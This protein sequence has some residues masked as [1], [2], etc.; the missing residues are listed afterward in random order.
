MKVEYIKFKN[1]KGKIKSPC[2]IYTDF[3]S[4]LV[5]KDNGKKNPEEYYTNKHQ[6]NIACSYSYKSVC[7]DDK[8]GKPFKT[9]LGKDAV[10]KFINIMIEE[11]NYCS[12]LI[13][14]YFSK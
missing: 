9:Y 14:K 2:M 6:K 7:V 13:K 11:I 1:F 10:Y 12:E 4:I 3:E 5:P 8:F